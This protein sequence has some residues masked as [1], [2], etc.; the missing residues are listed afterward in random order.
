[1]PDERAHV[2]GAVAS[3]GDRHASQERVL[4]A[5]EEILKFDSSDEFRALAKRRYHQIHDER[6]AA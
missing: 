3:L 6:K 5:L 2:A 1:M 4:S